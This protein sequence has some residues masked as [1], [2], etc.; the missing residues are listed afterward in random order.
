MSR[1]KVIGIDFAFNSIRLLS[2][3]FDYK[4]HFPSGFVSPVKQVMIVNDSTQGIE[5]QVLQK[6]RSII[7]IK[8][9]I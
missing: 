9:N 5:Y 4:I 6:G 2:T 3:A 1:V 7:G 8:I